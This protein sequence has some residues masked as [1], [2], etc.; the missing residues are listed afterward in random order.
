[1]CLYKGKY[2]SK[3]VLVSDFMG[4]GFHDCVRTGLTDVLKSIVTVQHPGATDC[5]T[6]QLQSE[7]NQEDFKLFC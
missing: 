1:M 2:I 5:E 3:Q 7:L 4:V 6:F